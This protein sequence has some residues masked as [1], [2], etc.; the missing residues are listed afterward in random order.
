MDSGDRAAEEVAAEAG[1]FFYGVGGEAV[2]GGWRC[3]RG[4]LAEGLADGFG[5]GFGGVDYGGLGA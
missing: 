3:V 2:E 4:E 5:G 1:K